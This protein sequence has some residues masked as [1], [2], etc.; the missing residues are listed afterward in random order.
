M[1]PKPVQQELASRPGLPR[2]RP[3]MK[4]KIACCLLVLACLLVSPVHSEDVSDIDS[5]LLRTALVV[6]DLERSVTFYEEALGFRRGFMGDI[7]RPSVTAMLGLAERQTARFAVLHGAESLKGEPVNSAMIG[8]LEVDGP[9]LPRMVRPADLAVGEAMMAVMTND[10]GAVHERLLGLDAR[11]LY[12]PTRSPDGSESELVV[13]DPDGIR[14]H[15]VE[16]HGE[17]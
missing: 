4:H 15:V 8:L 1:T 5:A 12:P 16:R 14:I 9:A 17:P 2:K 11:I 13:H 10:I 7:T 3:T 6:A